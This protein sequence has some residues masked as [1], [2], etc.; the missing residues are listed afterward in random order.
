MHPAEG[1][2][3]FAGSENAFDR[4]DLILEWLGQVD[5]WDLDPHHSRLAGPIHAHAV[6]EQMGYGLLQSYFATEVDDEVDALG[7]I[8]VTD[9]DAPVLRQGL[10]AE[11]G[12]D[13]AQTFGARARQRDFELRPFFAG[14]AQIVVPEVRGRFVD[15]HLSVPGRRG[16]TQ[17]FCASC[18]V[19]SLLLL[20]PC[21]DFF[22]RQRGGPT[23]FR[24]ERQIRRGRHEQRSEFDP[25]SV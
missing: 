23:E 21:S 11:N 20:E 18:G 24:D 15:Y 1:E 9:L 22:Q 5:S 4:L 2:K 8:F 7:L 6:F 17:D 3:T 12:P 19:Q 16:M 10:R 25:P 13:A 14:I